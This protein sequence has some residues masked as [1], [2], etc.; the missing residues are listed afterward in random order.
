MK[1]SIL[2]SFATLCI[3]TYAVFSLATARATAI[4]DD[5]QDTYVPDY[6]IGYSSPD[7]N[8]DIGGGASGVVF[9][10]SYWSHKQ[11]PDSNTHNLEVNTAYNDNTAGKH[12]KLGHP[13]ANT[14][15]VFKDDT[16]LAHHSHPH[17]ATEYFTDAYKLGEVLE[18]TVVDSS[19]NSGNHPRFFWMGYV[20][21][22]PTEQHII[23]LSDSL[24]QFTPFLACAATCGT[25]VWNYD[26]DEK[27]LGVNNCYYRL[28]PV[29]HDN[30]R[31]C[32][33]VYLDGSDWRIWCTLDTTATDYMEG[34]YT[35]VWLILPNNQRPSNGWDIKFATWGG[36]AAKYDTVTLDMYSSTM[37]DGL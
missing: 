25:H 27:H 19:W 33:F 9:K 10:W 35:C 8:L 34:G 32:G 31:H 22:F 5:D 6:V 36:P 4:Q 1:R 37:S 17:A 23:N 15:G 3:V 30:T 21:E 24:S 29:L 11:T 2:V 20:Q 16:C 12:I 14:D 13:T 7:E 18:Y 26:V 28:N